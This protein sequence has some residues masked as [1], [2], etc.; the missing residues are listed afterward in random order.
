MDATTDISG[1]FSDV[2]ELLRWRAEHHPERRAYT[3]CD[4]DR[5][6]EENVTYAELDADAR[7]VAARLT[8]SG[9]AGHRVILLLPPGRS[10]VAGFLGC[11]YAGSIAI[12][13][14]PPRPGTHLNRFLAIARA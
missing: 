9:A 12:P 6:P 11:I 14:F 10:F 8:E 3:F 13:A 5:S 2:G 1:R 4:G 7:A